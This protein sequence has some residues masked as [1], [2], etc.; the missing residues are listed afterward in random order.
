MEPR[1][2]DRVDADEWGDTIEAVVTAKWQFIGYEA[3][4]P[5]TASIQAVVIAE[6]EAW[7]QGA[8]PPT[9]ELYAPNAPYYF[10][11]GAGINNWF[12]DVW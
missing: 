12:R 11:Y 1:S 10:F 3:E 4:H 7:A 6:L 9:H 5:V 8:E 2:L